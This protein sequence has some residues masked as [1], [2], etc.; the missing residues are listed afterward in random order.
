MGGLDEG[1]GGHSMNL[2]HL[3]AKDVPESLVL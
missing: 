3:D 1:V 2:I